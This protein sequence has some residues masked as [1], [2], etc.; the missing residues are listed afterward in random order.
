M[1]KYQDFRHFEIAKKCL[2]SKKHVFLEKPITTN[3][4]DA[5]LLR[6]LSENNSL[7]LQVG[8]L[9]R[10]NNSVQKAKKII[11]ENSFGAI[12][13]VYFS[14]TNF[15]PIFQNRSVILDL[16]IHPVDIV[17]YIFGGNSKNIKCKRALEHSYIQS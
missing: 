11:D 2:E 4:E 3:L 12:H 15:E 10:F 9:Y 16:G 1:A 17:D 7:I 6:K 14:W 8:H 13:S 5:D